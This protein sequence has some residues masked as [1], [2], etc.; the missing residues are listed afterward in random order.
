LVIAEQYGFPILGKAATKLDAPRININIFLKYSTEQ[1]QGNDKY[2]EILRKFPDLR[3]SHACCNFIKE[4]PS[5]RL[6]NN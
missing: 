3:I 5:Q 2:Y 1:S 6:Q 4:Q